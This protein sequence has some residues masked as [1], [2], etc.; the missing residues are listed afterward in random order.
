MSMFDLKGTSSNNW[1]YSDPDKDNYSEFIQGTV[2]Q[3]DNP[4]SINFGTGK[5]EFWQDGNPKRNLRMT[6]LQA[7]G[8]E[9]NWT[10][11]PHAKSLARQAIVTGMD[12]YD[13]NNDGNMK[14]L[15]GL[16]VTVWTQPGTYNAQ[17]PRPWNFRIDGPG[18]ASA[19]RGLV[20]L[21]TQQAP[22][23]QNAVAPQPASAPQP[24]MT[25]V[26]STPPPANVV[27]QVQA[28]FGVQPQ[29]V[30]EE[31]PT[32]VYDNDIPF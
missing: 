5:P 20:D 1:N 3:I 32:S 13:A 4:Q 7:D 31:V 25:Q 10:F 9:V 11:A 30:R 23:L 14:M 6:L 2:V 17:R 27:Q 24:A 29:E 12:A 15:L 28:A 22:P 21:S 8:T 19:V 18:D 16:A 26:G